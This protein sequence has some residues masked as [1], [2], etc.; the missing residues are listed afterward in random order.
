MGDRVRDATEHTAL[1]ALVADHEQIR[2]ALGCELHQHLTGIALCRACLALDSRFT[3]LRLG[4]LEDLPQPSSRA[5]GPL[6]LDVPG[7]DCGGASRAL[8]RA[9]EHELRPKTT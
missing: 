4:P 1:H 8:K 7:V 3:Q 6:K 2:A 5:P 9:Q